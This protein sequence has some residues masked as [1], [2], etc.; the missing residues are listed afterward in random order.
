MRNLAILPKGGAKTAVVKDMDGETKRVE[1]GA[2]AV[3]VDELERE[4][5]GLAAIRAENE[6]I[7]LFTIEMRCCGEL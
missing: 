6:R 1:G 7:M 5:F 2:E 3:D 4:A